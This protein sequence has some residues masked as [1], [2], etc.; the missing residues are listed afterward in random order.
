MKEFEKK[1]EIEAFKFK[2]QQKLERLKH[3]LEVSVKYCLQHGYYDCYYHS[4]IP[5]AIENLLKEIISNNT[6]TFPFGKYK[7]YPVEMVLEK[8]E[9]YCK[10]FVRNVRGKDYVQL[11][12][13]DYL[14]KKLYGETEEE[15]EYYFEPIEIALQSILNTIP[16]LI[17]KEIDTVELLE[18]I[19]YNKNKKGYITFPDMEEDNEFTYYGDCIIDYG[20]TC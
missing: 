15:R 14:V 8:D 20:D 17:R 1:Q 18:K 16:M 4:S 19:K 3:E 12:I 13:I 7:D 11:K 2:K 9:E 6:L 10:W 5:E